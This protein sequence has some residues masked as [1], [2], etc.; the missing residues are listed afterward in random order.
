M[1]FSQTLRFVLIAASSVSLSHCKSTESSNSAD[2]K[3]TNAFFMLE[4]GCFALTVPGSS[5]GVVC[6]DGIGEEGIGGSGAHVAYGS[7]TSSTAWCAK[8]TSSGFKD[9]K[10]FLAFAPST[11]ILSMK[12]AGTSKSG[13]IDIQEAKESNTMSY[14]YLAYLKSSDMMSSPV[15]KAAG[16]N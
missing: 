7:Q 5:A 11:G 4:N 16:I 8:T 13:K 14:T 6:V 3:G 10:F 2:V 12:F 15:C 9:G 1:S